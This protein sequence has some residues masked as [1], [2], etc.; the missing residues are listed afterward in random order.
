MNTIS[1]LYNFQL[2]TRTPIPNL[3]TSKL[4]RKSYNKDIRT[5]E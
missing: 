1:Q 3:P 2:P 4:W 5:S